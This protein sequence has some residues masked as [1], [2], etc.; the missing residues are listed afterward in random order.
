MTEAANDKQQLKPM[1]ELI[2]QQS[3]RRPEASLANSGY[4]SEENLECLESADQPERMVEGFL[5]TGKQKHGEHPN[6]PSVVG[7][8]KGRRRWIG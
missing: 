2:E 8:R 3:G 6:L 5:A 1:V 4:C 7:C